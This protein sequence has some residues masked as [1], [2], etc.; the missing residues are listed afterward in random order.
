M[1]LAKEDL[2]QFKTTFLSGHINGPMKR[3]LPLA[4][5]VWIQTC[6]NAW[7]AWKKA[8]RAR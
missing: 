2:D 1:T 7:C 3:K 6:L 8:S 5:A 4:P